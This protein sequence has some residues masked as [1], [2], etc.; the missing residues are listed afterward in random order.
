MKRFARLGLGGVASVLILLAGCGQKSTDELVSSARNYLES[1][2]LSSAGIELR[3]ALQQSPDSGEARYLLGVLLMEQGLFGHAVIEMEKARD[4]KFDEARLAPR[5]ARALLSAGR[6]KEVLSRFADIRPQD[7]A[8]R[9]EVLTALAIALIEQGQAAAGEARLEEALQAQPNDEWA[10][11]T[12]A[13]VRASQGHVGDALQLTDKVIANGGDAGEAWYLK[14]RLLQFPGATQ[15]QRAAEAAYA[16]AMKDKRQLT[17]ARIALVELYLAEQRMVELKALHGEIRKADPKGP[18][19]QMIDAQ[20]AYIE[21]RLE[22][23]RQGLDAL[24]RTSPNNVRLLTFSG[25]VDLA[26]G[27]LLSAETQLGKAIN[28]PESPPTARRLLAQTYLRLGEPQKALG[29]L[30]PQ[31]EGAQADAEAL[32]LA[33]EASLQL[34]DATR[35]EQYFLEATRLKPSDA[36]LR[37][38]VALTDLARGSTGVGFA[39]LNEIAR[40]DPG[41]V[42]D[43]ALVSAH[44]KRGEFEPALLAVR[45]LESK[46]V[47][48]AG[49]ETLRGVVLRAKG[50]QDAA[51]AAFEAVLR[52]QPA[53]YV[54]T[55]SLAELD[56]SRGDLGAARRR[57]EEATKA[58]PRSVE[59]RLAL[60]R[61]MGNAG[62]TQDAIKTALESVVSA[63]PGELEPR[64]MLVTHLLTNGNA[65]GGL[66]VAQQADAAFPGRADV[67]DAL[68]RAQADA[69]NLEQAV[70][71]FGKAAALNPRSPLAYLRLADLQARRRDFAA[72]GASLRRAFEVA[73]DLEEVHGRMVHLARMT[74]NPSVPMAAAAELK[75]RFPTSPLGDLVEGDV[76]AMLK[77]WPA[78]ISAYRAGTTKK[79]GLSRSAI[80]LYNALSASGQRATA[81]KFADEWIESHASDVP[82]MRHVGERAMTNK[83]AAKAERLFQRVVAIDKSSAITFN[84]LAWLQA[85]RGHK[86]AV[87]NAEKAAALAPASP[88]VLDTLAMAL[89]SQRQFPRAVEVQQ[90]ALALAPADHNLR[91]SLAQIYVASGDREKATAELETL[92]ALGDRFPGQA[93]VQGLKQSLARR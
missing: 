41:D 8:A 61:L 56:L 17:A 67:L 25:T 91:L 32:A 71:T 45:R 33:G 39:A 22:D 37:T 90:R 73:P 63:F 84:N 81:E 50:D 20:I 15:D 52:M 82:F 19:T 10:L 55:A 53:H 4:L 88:F 92:A 76:H 75:R 44:L 89:A 80:R 42:A 23:S 62:A 29:S 87:A 12:K 9:A 11:L 85:Q 72:A 47:D 36:R 65:Q 83:D 57:L 78:A 18:F 54:A 2:N 14:G 60:V 46:A 34:G 31:L 21:G 27:A 43:R 74:K 70:S 26:R 7:A 6:P 68:G 93:I 38:A 3:A 49:V 24:L 16:R 48:K 5:L 77:N 51:R 28:L 86:D 66:V 13:R 40:S 64:L 69:G 35:A 79:D 1:G 30:R 59:P 58:N